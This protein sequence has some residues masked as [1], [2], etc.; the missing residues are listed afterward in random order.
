MPKSDLGDWANA[1]T[2]FQV[3]ARL[4]EGVEAPTYLYPFRD[5]KW[6]LSNNCGPPSGS[7]EYAK[8]ALGFPDFEITRMLC[9]GN[10]GKWEAVQP[11]VFKHTIRVLETPP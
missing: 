1:R 6:L 7:L 2:E 4:R 3:L 11:L 8:L 9:L 10:G 5:G